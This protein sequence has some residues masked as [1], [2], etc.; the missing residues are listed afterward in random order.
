M[1][2]VMPKAT[3][4]VFRVNASHYLLQYYALVTNHED[5][6]TME[7]QEAQ[8]RDRR[9]RGKCLAPFI[10]HASKLPIFVESYFLLG[11]YP[12]FGDNP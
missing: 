8:P 1:E 7:D 9:C 4:K 11:C 6:H 5:F 2:D 3:S 12:F 10:M